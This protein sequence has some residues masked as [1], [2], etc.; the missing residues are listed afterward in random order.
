MN[1]DEALFIEQRGATKMA[2]RQPLFLRTLA[3]TKIG[4]TVFDRLSEV[5]TASQIMRKQ[6]LAED[7]DARARVRRP[8]RTMKKFAPL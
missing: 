2:L 7:C 6:R 5:S 8:R 3:E 4:D 1:A